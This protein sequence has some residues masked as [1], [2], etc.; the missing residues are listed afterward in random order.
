MQCEGGQDMLLHGH[1]Y[2]ETQPHVFHML[3]LFLYKT[4]SPWPQK[5]KHAKQENSFP[6]I[7]V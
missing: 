2:T 6:S 4:T 7:A 5:P 1:G 3:Y